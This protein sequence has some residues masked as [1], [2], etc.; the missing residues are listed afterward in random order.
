MSEITTFKL[1]YYAPIHPVSLAEIDLPLPMGNHFIPV[2]G[3]KEK[4]EKV[5][6]VIEL[7]G[8]GAVKMSFEDEEPFGFMHDGPGGKRLYTQKTHGIGI[9]PNSS[10]WWNVTFETKSPLTSQDFDIYGRG[11]NIYITF[12]VPRYRNLEQESE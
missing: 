5:M 9:S 12:A 10:G 2:G 8:E 1:P 4:F 11:L 7:L 6:P 3:I